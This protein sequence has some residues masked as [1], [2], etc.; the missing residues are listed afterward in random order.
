M[1]Q[2]NSPPVWV[3]ESFRFFLHHSPSRHPDL[4]TLHFTCVVIFPTVTRWNCK[5]SIYTSW[6]ARGVIDTSWPFGPLLLLYLRGLSSSLSSSF[7]ALYSP[8]VGATRWMCHKFSDL[9]QGKAAFWHPTVSSF[10]PRWRLTHIWIV[11]TCEM[12]DSCFN[13]RP[14][15]WV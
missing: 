14:Y 15:C 10:V 12:L 6:T 2:L 4:N 13:K 1:L 5:R 7:F 11:L 9:C 8:S 3:V